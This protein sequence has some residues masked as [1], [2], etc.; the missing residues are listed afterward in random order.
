MPTPT[1]DEV[2]E[3]LLKQVSMWFDSAMLPD[4][5]DQTLVLEKTRR[6]NGENGQL[7][8]FG[9]TLKCTLGLASFVA[10]VEDPRIITR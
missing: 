2:K 4:S 1:R 5:N 9:F 6:I 10:P 3:L 7:H 8:G